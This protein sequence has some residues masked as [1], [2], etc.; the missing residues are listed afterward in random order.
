MRTSCQLPDYY[1]KISLS[2]QDMAYLLS[3]QDPVLNGIT[4]SGVGKRLEA[5]VAS[6]KASLKS[7]QG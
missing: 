3:F 4:L 5:W 1:G 6:S 2:V 7:L